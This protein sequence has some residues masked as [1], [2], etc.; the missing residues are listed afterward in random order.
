MGAP[1]ARVYE[2][3]RRWVSQNSEVIILTGFPNHPTGVIPEDY[4]GKSFLREDVDGIKII[5]TYIFATANKGFIKRILSYIS[6]MFS[7]IIQ[8]T[9]TSGKQDVI[10]A[11]SPQFFVGIAGYIIKYSL[12]L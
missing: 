8:G 5:R 9:G 7:S 1:S 3:S 2:L 4:R 12:Y 10:I 6:F 11:S